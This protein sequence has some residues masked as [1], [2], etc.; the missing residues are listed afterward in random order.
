MERAR[1]RAVR[2]RHDLL[3]VFDGE[4]PQQAPDLLGSRNA[5]DTIVE[6]TANLDVLGGSSAPIAASAH[7]SA[8]APHA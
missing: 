2:E 7:G 1:E 5:D 3:I 8:S 4:P 6:I